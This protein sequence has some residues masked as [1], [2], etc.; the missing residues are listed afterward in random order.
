MLLIAPIITNAQATLT[1]AQYNVENLFDTTNDRKI[2]DEDFLP[3]GANQWTDA[4]YQQKIKNL[5][6]VILSINN[7]EGADVI[8]LCEIENRKVLNDLVACNTLK[9]CQYQIVHFDSPDERGIDVAFLYKKNVLKVLCQKN[10]AVSL[11]END[12]TR[13]VLLMQAKMNNGAVVNFIAAHFPSRGE[14]EAQSEPKRIAAAKVVRTI[15]DDIMKKDPKSYVIIGGD[16]ND[17]PT[18]TSISRTIGAWGTAADARHLYNPFYSLQKSGKGT[19]KYKGQWNMLD[20]IMVSTNTLQ[21]GSKLQ[22]VMQSELVYNPEFIQETKQQYAGQPKRTYA[23]KNYL[24]GYSDHFP[25]VVQL[26][27]AK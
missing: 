8:S 14:G 1:V 20:H 15:H 27:M 12:K 11:P 10:Y 13:D 3:D 16:F 7:G 2:N 22:Y 9:K 6:Q 17:E 26:S 23:G 25:V 5:A 19:Y 24:G 21:S 4:R 18:N